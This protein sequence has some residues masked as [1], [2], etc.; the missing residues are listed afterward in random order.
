LN[1]FGRDLGEP[2]AASLAPT[3]FDNDIAALVPP[4]F[5]K[6]LYKCGGPLAL[7]SRR[8]GPSNPMTGSAACCARAANGHVTATPPSNIL[9]SRRFLSGPGLIIQ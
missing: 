4:E 1:E 9:N 2:L 3:I 6:P 5:A 7:R 8:I